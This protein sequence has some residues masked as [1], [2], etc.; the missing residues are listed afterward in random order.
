M[1]TTTAGYLVRGDDAPTILERLNGQWHELALRAFMVIVLAHW[2]EHLVQ[3]SQIYALGWPS[4][5]AR[6]VLGYCSR[7]W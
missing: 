2:A 1:F 3:A 6:G 7:G 5:E 4:P